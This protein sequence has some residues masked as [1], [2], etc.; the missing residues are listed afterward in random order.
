MDTNEASRVRQLKEVGKDLWL[1]PEQ[2]DLIIEH[3]RGWVRSLIIMAANTG[4]R[5][6]EVC[7][8]RW[9]DLEHSPGWIRVDAAKTSKVRFVPINSKVR[10]LLDAQTRHFGESG[11]LPWVF[12][13]TRRKEAYRGTGFYSGFKA[14]TKA[15]AERL[16][17]LGRVDEATAVRSST[18]HT[19]RHSFCSWAIRAGIP[20]AEVQE[21]LG[22]GSDQMTRRYLHLQPASKERR[23]ALEVLADGRNPASDVEPVSNDAASKEG[24]L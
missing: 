12:F 3:A 4:L 22:H 17:K 19:L 11:P 5:S 21:Y 1:T 14:A 6:G 7:G 18:V 15:A 9:A 13:S 23:N 20:I 24:A 10:A 16:D 2:V 8:L